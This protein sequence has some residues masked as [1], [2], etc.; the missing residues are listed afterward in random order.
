MATTLG[1]D[2]EGDAATALGDRRGSRDRGWKGFRQELGCTAGF[3]V[4]G[5]GARAL[6][7][8]ARV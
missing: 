3:L 2:F 6:E 1:Q 5:V 4:Q 7:L 8:G